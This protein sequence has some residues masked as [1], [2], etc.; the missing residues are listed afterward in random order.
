[1]IDHLLPDDYGCEIEGLSGC[2]QQQ[3]QQQ[4]QQQK[5]FSVI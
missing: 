4:Q 3:Q 5:T 2:K 1:M